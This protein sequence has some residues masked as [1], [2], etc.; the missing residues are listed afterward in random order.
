MLEAF[1]YAVLTVL[2]IIIVVV[3]VQSMF[4]LIDSSSGL[5]N[6][7]GGGMLLVAVLVPLTL[8][9]YAFRF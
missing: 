3:Y 6:F 4:I 8:F 9:F 7:L 5:E 2:A 1:G